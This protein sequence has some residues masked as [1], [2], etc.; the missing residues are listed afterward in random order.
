MRKRN[1]KYHYCLKIK[2]FSCVLKKAETSDIF[3]LKISDM[4]PQAAGIIQLLT[5]LIKNATPIS[6]KYGILRNP[7]RLLFHIKFK[8]LAARLPI[9]G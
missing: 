2:I 4:T 6:N 9:G 1:L 3:L 7:D 8:I 5:G